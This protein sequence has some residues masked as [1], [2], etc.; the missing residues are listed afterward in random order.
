MTP[1]VYLQEEDAV[2]GESPWIEVLFPLPSWAQPEEV[3]LTYQPRTCQLKIRFQANKRPHQRHTLG[4]GVLYAT[5]THAAAQVQ[6]VTPAMVERYYLDWLHSDGSLSVLRCLSVRLYKHHPVSW[7]GVFSDNGCV[8]VAPPSVDADLPSCVLINLALDRIEA[9]EAAV[10]KAQ[11]TAVCARSNLFGPTFGELPYL[12]LQASSTKDLMAEITSLQL[13]HVQVCGFI[14]H[15][16]SRRDGLFATADAWPGEDYYS[17]ETVRAALDELSLL[18]GAGRH[19]HVVFAVCFGA[20]LIRA[21]E[22]EREWTIP[23]NLSVSG[24]DAPVELGEQ[25]IAAMRLLLQYEHGDVGTRQRVGV[26]MRSRHHDNLYKYIANVVNKKHVKFEYRVASALCVGA[27]R[28]AYLVSERAQGKTLGVPTDILVQSRPATVTGNGRSTEL[29]CSFSPT[30]T[31]TWWLF[32]SPNSHSGSPSSSS[33]LSAQPAVD[34]SYQA[35]PQD[36]FDEPETAV[37]DLAERKGAEHDARDAQQHGAS[38]QSSSKR[39]KDWRAE[40]EELDRIMGAI[41][42]CPSSNAKSRRKQKGRTASST[43]SDES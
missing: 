32:P 2:S 21:I 15:G 6:E 8:E 23:H 3:Y 7:P 9:A 5:I 19:L 4:Q 16:S 18:V 41:D 29:T 42:S 10:A 43:Q 33:Q 27:D 25:P 24:F 31:P 40:E 30:L 38:S 34:T 28:N 12:G 22:G 17:V 1:F 26:A 20:R 14:A 36:L 11:A 39:N 37:K 13:A 35:N